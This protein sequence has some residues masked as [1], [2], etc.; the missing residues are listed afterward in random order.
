MTLSFFALIHAV[1]GSKTT[2]AAGLYG[3]ALKL[4]IAAPPVDG[5][6]NDAIRAWLAQQLGVRLAQ[7]ALQSGATSRQKRF[8][9]QAMTD[10][11]LLAAHQAWQALLRKH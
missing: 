2:Q 3:D 5:K 6:A 11:D 1:P 8:V 9:V 4:K 10:A 7:V